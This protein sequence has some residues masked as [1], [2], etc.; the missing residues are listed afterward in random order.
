MHP[1]IIKS[2]G[3]MRRKTLVQLTKIGQWLEV[4]CANIVM[5]KGGD[6][7]IHNS[8]AKHLSIF[9]HFLVAVSLLSVLVMKLPAC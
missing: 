9:D 1:G 3:T 4:P 6:F 2:K 8:F 7:S 5:E